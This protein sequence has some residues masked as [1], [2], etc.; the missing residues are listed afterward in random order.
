MPQPGTKQIL[1]LK[2]ITKMK[3]SLERFS[4]RV[5]QAEKESVSVKIE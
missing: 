5:E 3:N 4:N 1:K 2:S